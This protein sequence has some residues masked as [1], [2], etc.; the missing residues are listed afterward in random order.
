[1]TRTTNNIVVTVAGTNTKLSATAPDGTSINITAD[2]VL[3]IKHGSLVSTATSGF[4]PYSTVESWCY[5][6]PTKLGEEK[7]NGMGET[8]AR[9]E[10]TTQIP[11]GQH[12][13]VVRGLNSAGQSVTI[14]FAMRVIEDSLV[15]RIATSPVTLIILLLALLFAIFIPSRLRRNDPMK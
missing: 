9:Y 7:T 15:T 3:E 8:Q 1:M 4:A 11:S 12:H 10:I 2:G 5:S 14:G 6:T 13:L